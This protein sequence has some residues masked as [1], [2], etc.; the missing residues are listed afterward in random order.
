MCAPYIFRT[1]ADIQKVSVIIGCAQSASSATPGRCIAL[2]VLTKTRKT[3]PCQ[4]PRL[5]RRHLSR[6]HE[7]KRH[8]PLTPPSADSNLR[9]AAANRLPAVCV[10][11]TYMRATSTHLASGALRRLPQCTIP[12]PGT[13]SDV[14]SS[15]HASF[16]TRTSGQW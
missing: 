2:A 1:A 14:F 15:S 4:R 8:R 9:D 12:A 6:R 5:C 7:R 10:F 3:R 16:F 13:Q 11:S